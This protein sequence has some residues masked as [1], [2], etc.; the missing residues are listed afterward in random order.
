MLSY[1]LE[2]AEL[3]PRKKQGVLLSVQVADT[4]LDSH[5]NL[6]MGLRDHRVFI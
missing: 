4:A 3:N 5:M 6:S 2:K 1:F